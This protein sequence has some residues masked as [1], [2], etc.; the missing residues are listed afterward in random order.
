MRKTKIHNS[1]IWRQICVFHATPKAY[2]ADATPPL[3]LSP[4]EVDTSTSVGFLPSG[5][6]SRPCSQGPGPLRP[7]AVGPQRAQSQVLREN[8][9]Q[10]L[11][12]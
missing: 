11:L 5:L 1:T 6:H 9:P 8:I 10:A 7:N 2:P 4:G 3:V 12:S